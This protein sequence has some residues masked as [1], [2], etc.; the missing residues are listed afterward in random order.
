[1]SY[2]AK[3]T[4]EL[5]T[6]GQKIVDLYNSVPGS[7]GPYANPES[8]KAVLNFLAEHLQDESLHEGLLSQSKLLS[9]REGFFQ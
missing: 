9:L 2:K 1:M 3:V 7:S 6:A 4:R 5:S 8:L